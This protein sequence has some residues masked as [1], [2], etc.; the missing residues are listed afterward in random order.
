MIYVCVTPVQYVCECVPLSLCNCRVSAMFRS[1]T[2][3]VC[4]ISGICV[5]LVL[6]LRN[7]CECSALCN[8]RGVRS[9]LV[10]K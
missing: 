8:E 2:C 1:A 5:A 9:E 10:S 4:V 6:L 3:Y 7:L